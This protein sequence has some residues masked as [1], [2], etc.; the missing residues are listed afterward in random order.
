MITFIFGT[1]T[2]SM[3]TVVA[4]ALARVSKDNKE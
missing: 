2:G 3:L 4:L 1:I